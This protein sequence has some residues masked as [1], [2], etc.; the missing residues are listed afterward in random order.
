MA[1]FSESDMAVQVETVGGI[2]GANFSLATPGNLSNP[3]AV[4]LD[5]TGQHLDT[6]TEHSALTRWSSFQSASLSHGRLLAG[7]MAAAV[8]NARTGMPLITH[9]DALRDPTKA[10]ALCTWAESGYTV[11]RISDADLEAKDMD[12]L[13][14]GME[15]TIEYEQT[16]LVHVQNRL[17]QLNILLGADPNFEVT[18][19][20]ENGMSMLGKGYAVD[21]WI[22]KYGEKTA[23]K[24]NAG[25]ETLLRAFQTQTA[26]ASRIHIG[27]VGTETL[28]PLHYHVFGAN[29]E[30]W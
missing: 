30:N 22:Q 20:G 13:I 26:F 16:Y 4:S 24:F 21:Q 9:Q 19:G 5:K 25:L 11:L 23:D 29:A 2:M 7:Q 28:G 1:Q 6:C 14:A 8:L 15:D 27:K 10:A 3:K 18:I 17:N 12:S